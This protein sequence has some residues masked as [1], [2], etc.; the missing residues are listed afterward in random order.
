[1]GRGF[2][3]AEGGA[4]ESRIFGFESVAKRFLAVVGSNVDLER[5]AKNR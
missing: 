4:V 5:L 3:C 2:L 1:M